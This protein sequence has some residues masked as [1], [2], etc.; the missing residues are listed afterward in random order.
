MRLV[1][2]VLIVL[3][4]LSGMPTYGPL[5]ASFG[6]A[7]LSIGMVVLIIFVILLLMGHL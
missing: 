3:L 2:I 4:I 5:H 1:L 7:P 6:Y